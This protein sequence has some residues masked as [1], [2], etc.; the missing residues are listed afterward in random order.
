M[1]GSHL[2]KPMVDQCGL[3]D[4]SPGNDCND[5]YLP[6]RPCS[7]QKSDILISAKNITS[8]NR[9]SGYGNPFRCRSYGRLA[10]GDTRSGRG[11]LLQVLTSDSASPVDSIYYRRDG[12]QKFSRILKSPPRVFLKESLE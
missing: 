10:S 7:L 2:R 5:V 8:S 3:P 1:V 6:V 9:Q 4:T 11:C 12:L